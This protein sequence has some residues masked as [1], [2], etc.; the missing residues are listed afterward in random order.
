MKYEVP[1]INISK[2]SVENIVTASAA[3][4]AAEQLNAQIAGIQGAHAGNTAVYKTT[5]NEWV[6]NN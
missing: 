5:M 4:I 6:A 3:S 1:E 2:F